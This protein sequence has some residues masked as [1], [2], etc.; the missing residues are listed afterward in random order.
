[1]EISDGSFSGESRDLMPAFIVAN[2]A[3]LSPRNPT[4]FSSHKCHRHDVTNSTSKGK[5]SFLTFQ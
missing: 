5:G 4:V 2:W 3:F 1:M